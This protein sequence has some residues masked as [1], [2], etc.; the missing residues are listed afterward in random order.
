MTE[1][2]IARQKRNMSIRVGEGRAGG[3]CG[4][5]QDITAP[6]ENALPIVVDLDELVDVVAGA[7][8]V[9][10]LVDERALVAAVQPSGARRGGAGRDVRPTA[11]RSDRA[12]GG[13]LEVEA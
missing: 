4:E 11:H 13:A 2:F 1:S 7:D 5:P 3:K 10:E 8:G 9:G 12:A 6:H